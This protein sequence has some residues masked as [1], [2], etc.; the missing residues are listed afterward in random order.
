MRMERRNRSMNISERMLQHDVTAGKFLRCI[1]NDS[2]ASYASSNKSFCCSSFTTKVPTYILLKH[3]CTL[4][5]R[6]IC[7]TRSSGCIKGPFHCQGP[8]WRRTSE[9]E[10]M[11]SIPELLES[12]SPLYTC[13]NGDRSRFVVLRRVQ[14]L[15][16]WQE[17]FMG[18][19]VGEGGLT[20]NRLYK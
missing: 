20:G 18:L 2:T 16:D 19:E 7:V 15:T 13:H 5:T 14:Q 4:L 8:F 3:C 1:P 6:F 10:N 12:W 11:I 17:P 9:K